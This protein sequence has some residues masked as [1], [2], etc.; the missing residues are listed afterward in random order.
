VLGVVA[1]CLAFL[2]AVDPT[3]ADTFRVSVV[4]DFECVAVEDPDDEAM[5][6]RDSES[7]RGCQDSEEQH[8]EGPYREATGGMKREG[9]GSLTRRC[10]V[11][12]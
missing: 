9:R 8:T 6:L 10:I 7:M 2:R 1:V 4:E 3:E 5:I 11:G 12:G